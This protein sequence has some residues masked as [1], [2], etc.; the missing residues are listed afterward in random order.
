MLCDAQTSGG[1]LAAVAPDQADALA[2]ALL[3]AGCQEV[4]RIG[5][6]CEG[7]SE[8]RVLP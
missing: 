1:L 2:E 4:A 6:V 3:T 7:A 5:T 8:V